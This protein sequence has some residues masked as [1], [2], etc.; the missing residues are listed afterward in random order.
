VHKNYI[1]S[2]PG[3]RSVVLVRSGARGAGG[4]NGVRSGHMAAAV[5]TRRMAA[6]MKRQQRT[7]ENYITNAWVLVM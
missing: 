4:Y 6:G 1:T 5:D 2:T 3:A 7:H